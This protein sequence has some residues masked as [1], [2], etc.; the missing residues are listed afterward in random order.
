MSKK[1][2]FAT[3]IFLWRNNQESALSSS[4]VRKM[5]YSEWCKKWK[6]LKANLTNSAFATCTFGKKV[7]K[8]HNKVPE[9]E[10]FFTF[11]DLFHENFFLIL[12]WF[13][14]PQFRMQQIFRISHLTFVAELFVWPFHCRYREKTTLWPKVRPPPFP[15]IFDLTCQTRAIRTR[16]FRT[17]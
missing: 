15:A 3:Y 8:I 6:I 17:W 16:N 13:P 2:F 12:Y 4:F 10:Y 1:Y 14:S 9:M 11:F 5:N 7:V